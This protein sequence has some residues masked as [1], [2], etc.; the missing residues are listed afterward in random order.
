MKKGES[1][2]ENGIFFMDTG[3]QTAASAPNRPS[4]GPFLFSVRVRFFRLP[5]F[6]DSFAFFFLHLTYAVAD[7]IIQLSAALPQ[8]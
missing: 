3:F 6:P 1:Q 2:S 7:F 4:I 8:Q 5:F